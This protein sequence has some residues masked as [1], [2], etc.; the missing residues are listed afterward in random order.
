[1][2]AATRVRPAEHAL[3]P[4]AWAG[5]ARRGLRS[6]P[7]DGALTPQQDAADALALGFPLLGLPLSGFSLLLLAL[8]DFALLGL[9]LLL[10]RGFALGGFPLLLLSLLD[11]AL[12]GFFLLLLGGFALLDFALGGFPF[13]LL[14]F[15]QLTLLDFALLLLLLNLALLSGFA[16]PAGGGRNRA[17]TRVAARRRSR[18]RGGLPPPV[19]LR[20]RLGG[21]RPLACGQR[22]PSGAVRAGAGPAPSGSVARARR[23]PLPG[24]GAYRD[25]RLQLISPLGQAMGLGRVDRSPAILADDGDF[26]VE[27]GRGRR[28]RS[29]ATTGREMT[30]AGG[31]AAGACRVETRSESRV[32]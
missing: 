22:R 29:R 32:G 5:P 19:G 7:G 1:M 17:L 10:L 6:G 14:T 31:R 11:R 28:R 25:G 12:L 23:V 18:R 30:A 15:L 3:A 13:L 8:L 20:S 21:H 9:F 24:D 26:L 16:L 27:A 4:G 2:V